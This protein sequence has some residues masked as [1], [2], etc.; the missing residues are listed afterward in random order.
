MKQYDYK[1]NVQIQYWQSALSEPHTIMF[2]RYKWSDGPIG[3]AEIIE[4]S[5]KEYHNVS[6]ASRL[7]LQQVLTTKLYNEQGRVTFL[8]N[9]DG[10]TF[11]DNGNLKDA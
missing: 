4:N 5:C 11:S 9:Y 8:H 2:Y 10:W 3:Q 1:T 6:F 7:R